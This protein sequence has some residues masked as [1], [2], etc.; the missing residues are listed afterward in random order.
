MFKIITKITNL[1]FHSRQAR[2]CNKKGKN[3]KQRLR[4]RRG[5]TG[6]MMP[7]SQKKKLMVQNWLLF[8]SIFKSVSF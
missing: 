7:L 5:D 4:Q 6:E 1:A 2:G 8:K 3:T